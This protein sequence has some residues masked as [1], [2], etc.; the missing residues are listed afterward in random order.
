MLASVDF[1]P[2]PLFPG[3][4]APEPPGNSLEIRALMHAYQSFFEQ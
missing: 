3:V 4:S 1:A 2:N